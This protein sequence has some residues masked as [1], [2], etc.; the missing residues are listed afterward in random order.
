MSGRLGQIEPKSMKIRHDELAKEMKRRGYN[1]QSPYR[2]PNISYLPDM[3][4]DVKESFKD[5]INRCSD[6]NNR[7]E[8]G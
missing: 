4:V 1:H 7:N 2:M 5:L 6:C 8:E 3:I